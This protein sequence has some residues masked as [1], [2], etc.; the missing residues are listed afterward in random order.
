MVIALPR[1]FRCGVKNLLEFDT[2][3]NYLLVEITGGR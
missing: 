1:V 2:L 3:D